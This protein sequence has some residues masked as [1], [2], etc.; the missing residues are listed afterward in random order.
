[1]NSDF[2]SE[3]T[4]KLCLS[5]TGF[6]VKPGDNPQEVIVLIDPNKEGFEDVLDGIGSYLDLPDGE[7]IEL[8]VL[9]DG[10]YAVCVEFNEVTDEEAL[11]ADVVTDY[12]ND[13]PFWHVC[14]TE[15]QVHVNALRLG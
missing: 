4:I 7:D 3:E 11:Q 10:M 12:D 8:V 5:L 9:E 15:L 1:M 13:V 14:Y 6:A 2:P